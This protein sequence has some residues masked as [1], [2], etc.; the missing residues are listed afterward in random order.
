MDHLE[1]ILL[2]LKNKGY[3]LSKTRNFIL[4]SIIKNHRPFSVADF[5]K[6]L[7]KNKLSVKNFYFNKL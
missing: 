1:D 4:R 2:R 5:Q 7:K 3:R 6:L